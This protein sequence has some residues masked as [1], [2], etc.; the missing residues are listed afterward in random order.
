VRVLSNR[1]A[2]RDCSLRD[3]IAASLP[4][5]QGLVDAG[6]AD[7]PVVV[8]RAVPARFTAAGRPHRRAT[9]RDAG[10]LSHPP[11]GPARNCRDGARF[12][13]P[14]GGGSWWSPAIA[15]PAAGRGRL[16]APKPH[17]GT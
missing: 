17:L 4:D 14:D 2:T 1:V 5:C 10:R 7:Y 8:H 9:G 12:A 6:D 3:K 15:Q 13:G 11:P 16:T